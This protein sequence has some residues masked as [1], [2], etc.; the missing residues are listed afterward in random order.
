MPRI[1]AL[2]MSVLL[3][4]YSQNAFARA[5]SCEA[6][7]AMYRFGTCP[8][9]SINNPA[10]NFVGVVGSAVASKPTDCGVQITVRV[11]HSSSGSLP[12]KVDIDVGPCAF[13]KGAVGETISAVIREAPVRTG[14][15]QGSP[16][17]ATNR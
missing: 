4:T 16:Y 3:L 12:E 11:T 13:W 6:C 17:C 2:F 7:R 8:E 15:Y 10:R 9:T 14:V 1:A 5:A